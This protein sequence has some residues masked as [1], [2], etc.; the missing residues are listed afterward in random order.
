MVVEDLIEG[1]GIMK[2]MTMVVVLVVAILGSLATTASTQNE[3]QYLIVGG[4]GYASLSDLTITALNGQPRDSA[5]PTPNGSIAIGAGAYYLAMPQVAVGAEVSWLDFGTQ[6]YE[7]SD[8]SY[9]AIP[10]TAQA[11]YMIPTNSMVTP[12]ATGG[13]GLYHLINTEKGQST[14]DSS[15]DV[16]GFN[17]GGGVKFDTGTI[18]DF[19]VDV[20]FHLGMNP[21]LKGDTATGE[22]SLETSDWKMLTVMGRVFF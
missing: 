20:R 5:N 17:V 14:I 11:L 22:R 6:K 16:F 15:S 19:G 3:R 4:V 9:S 8:D 12:F 1:R 10:V 13:L 18:L 21:N 2:R 7:H